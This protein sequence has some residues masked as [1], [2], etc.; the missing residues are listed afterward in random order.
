[1]QAVVKLCGHRP[2]VFV[3]ITIIAIFSFSV[4]AGEPEQFANRLFSETV[5]TER[6]ERIP[7]T[8]NLSPKELAHL[9]AAKDL[10]TEFFRR[11]KSAHDKSALELLSDSYRANYA[12][13]QKFYRDHFDY[14]HIISYRIYNFWLDN[15]Q[16]VIR[17]QI[18]IRETLEGVDYITQHVAILTRL[19]QNWEIH[20]LE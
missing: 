1:M 20:K 17:F 3:G 15:D 14:D 4:S 19:K 6:V 5:I 18:D 13:S 8:S 11:L 16:K 10:L 7:D 12:S 2:R 9:Y